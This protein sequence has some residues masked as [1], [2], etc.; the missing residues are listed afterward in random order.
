MS[1][2][3]PDRYPRRCVALTARDRGCRFP[4]GTHT[5]YVDAHHVRPWADGGETSLANTLL[6]CDRHHTLVHEGGFRVVVDGARAHFFHPAGIEL[7]EVG[8]PGTV[9][10]RAYAIGAPSPGWDGQ[11]VDYDAAV[12]SLL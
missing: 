9:R 5:R 12:A 4:G 8:A 1:V 6:L 2:A 10:P 3:R 7:P 11:R